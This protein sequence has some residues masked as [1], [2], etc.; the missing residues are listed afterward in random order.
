M[1]LGRD[2]HT[3][4]DLAGERI[5]KTIARSGLCSRRDAERLIAEGRVILNGQRLASPAVNVGPKDT[6]LVD[7]KALS[8]AE[9]PRL[10]RYYKPKGRVTT[11]RDPQGRPT[12]FEALPEELGRVISI[13]RLDFNTE[14]LLLLTNDGALARHLESP[15]TGWL[16]R[17]RVRVNGK[18][19][20][21]ALDALADG[22]EIE[23]MKYGPIEGKLDRVQGANCWLTL[24]L[25]EGKNREVRRIMDHMGLVVNRLIR[26]SFGPFALAE[27]EPGAVEEVKRRVLA[28]QL[29]DDLAT[30]L[31]L[32]EKRQNRGDAPATR[33]VDNS[34]KQPPRAG[35]PAKSSR[36]P[37]GAS[38]RPAR[39]GLPRPA[40]DGSSR[41]ASDGS[42]RPARDGSSR[43]ARDSSSRTARDGSPHPAREGSSRPARDGSPRPARDDSSRPAREG[44]SRSARDSSS[45]TARDGSSRPARDGSSRSAKDSSPRPPKG[46][47][48]RPPSK[49]APGR[50]V[51]SA[52]PRRE[53]PS[54]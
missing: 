21:S 32:K 43:P 10:W 48:D 19:E 36:P 11:H 9:P 39:D 51:R 1:S 3:S 27:L 20:Q 24:G 53:R 28:D 35:A 7:G 29:G 31:G 46:A 17:Y 2:T 4:E 18:V 6:I 15:S 5:A 14:G 12:V 23:G 8:A 45:R 22:V 37:R 13:G 34:A 38:S 25:R 26:L 42:S 40:R 54:R 44:S 49:T 47:A 33:P 16:R 52:K 50:P 41:S 30:A